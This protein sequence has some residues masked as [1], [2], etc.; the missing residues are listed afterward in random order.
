MSKIIER[1]R[2]KLRKRDKKK[3]KGRIT[4]EKEMKRGQTDIRNILRKTKSIAK[5][6]EREKYI[7]L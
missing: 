4:R 2:K 3:I 5:K 6:R 7:L 1:K